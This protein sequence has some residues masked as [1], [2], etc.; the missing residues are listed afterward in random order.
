MAKKNND[1]IDNR[2]DLDPALDF[3]DF[4]FPDPFAKDDRKPAIKIASGMF[5]GAKEGLRDT[6]FLKA[7]LRDTLPQG[8]GQTIDFADKISASARSL[9][10]EGAKEIKP[11]IKDFQRLAAR[12]TPKDS[13]LVPKAIA[14]MIK[15]WEEEHKNEAAGGTLS[16]ERQ[17]EAIVSSQLTEI[18]QAQQTQLTQDRKEDIGRENIKEGIEFTRHRD[19]FSVANTTAVSISRL[20]QYTLNVG[21]K[22]QKKAIELQFRQL[23]A[24]QDTLAFMQKDAAKRDQ[25]LCNISKNTALPEYVKITATESL[26]Q[27]AKN[28][29]LGSVGNGLF[30]ARDNL[31]AKAMG[32]VR[33]KLKGSWADKKFK[34]FDKGHKLA[35]M[36]ENM[37]QKLGD[38][39]RSD[40]WDYDYSLLSQGIRLAQGLLPGAGTD[41]S[42]QNYTSKNMFEAFSFT[43]RS[44]KSLNEVIP[45]LLSRLL[46][47]A[48][49][50]R[51]G[52][53]K[54]ALTEYD[55]DAGRFT[56]AGK[57]E[58]SAMEKVA[59]AKNIQKTQKR[60]DEMVNKIQ[61]EGPALS[62][63]ARA[64]LKERLLKASADGREGVEAN[65]GMHKNY[66][67]VSEGVRDE[68]VPV[69][70]RYLEG[71]SPKER[72]HFSQ[73]YNGLANDVHDSRAAI[74]HQMNMGAAHLLRKEGVINRQ[75]TSI[76][77]KALFERYLRPTR[78]TPG[79]TPGTGAGGSPG[80]PGPEG[81][82]N[83]SPDSGADPNGPSGPNGPNGPGGPSPLPSP[84]VRIERLL[85]VMGDSALST[86]DSAA[87]GAGMGQG[88]QF[89][90]LS[91]D[92]FS[93]D[94]FRTAALRLNRK[95][96][97]LQKKGLKE[98]A[99]NAA[100]AL[101]HGASRLGGSALALLGQGAD[102]L[103]EGGLNLLAQGRGSPH[104][105][106]AQM[107]LL[108][109]RDQA[110]ALGHSTQA[111]ASAAVPQQLKTDLATVGNA[112]RTQAL[113][114]YVLGEVQ[115]R[116][117]AVK[118][119][120]G[121]YR[122][123]VTKKILTHQDQIA[124]EVEDENGNL[125]ISKEELLRLA[126][127][128]AK[129]NTLSVFN[130]TKALGESL[131]QQHAP[132]LANALGTL[133]TNPI[134]AATMTAAL[135]A[136]REATKA[137]VAD[138][139][140][141]GSEMPR[142]LAGK[143][144]AGQYHNA[145]TGEPIFHQ[146]DIASEIKDETGAT[147][148]AADELPKVGTYEPRTRSFLFLRGAARAAWAVTKGLW[149]FQTKIALPM[150]KANLRMLKA[151]ATWG[152]DTGLRAVGLKRDKCKDVY[153]G[154]EREPR[155]YAARMK[156]G[157]YR[158]AKSG[159]VVLHHED[160][161]G[162][163]MD[164]DG[165]IVLSDDDLDN[166]RVY[167][168]VLGLFNPFKLGAK[169]IKAVGRAAWAFQS[170]IA[171]KLSK[172][173][174][175]LMGQGFKAVRAVAR[176]IT[177]PINVYVKGDAKPT[178]LARVMREGG[179][180][181][182]KTKKVIMRASEIDGP[183]EDAHGETLLDEADLE[184]GLTDVSGE[185]I[186]LSLMGKIGQGL[187]KLGKLFSLRRKLAPDRRKTVKDVVQA[188]SENAQQ[189]T[190]ELLEDI[191]AIFADKF[192]KKKA[193]GDSDG[194]GVRDGSYSDQQ[195]KKKK[196]A[197][198]KAAK[199]A[200]N[201][202]APAAKG[203][204][205]LSGVL[206]AADEGSS[207]WSMG[208][209]LLPWLVGGGAAAGTVGAAGAAGT[210][211][212]GTAGAAGAV[213]AAGAAGA[214]VGIGSAA[215]AT[216]GAIGGGL[217]AF[218][219]SPVVLAVGLTALAG[220]GLYKGAQYLTRGD[221]TP[222][223]KLRYVQYGFPLEH[224]EHASEVLG[225]EAY[226]T[227]F[228]KNEGGKLSLNEK[229]CSVKEMV[230]FFG[231][232]HKESKH[233]EI[234]FAWYQNRFKPVFLTH[235]SAIAAIKGKP[236]LS[237]VEGLSPAL[238][239]SYLEAVR[240]SEG[241]YN[242]RCLPLEKPEFKAADGAA[243]QAV[244][245]GL[246][247]DLPA[248]DDKG[249]DAALAKGAPV[250]AV[251]AAALAPSASALSGKSFN[252]GA[253]R[254]SD[255]GETPNLV[256]TVS[257]SVSSANVGPQGR[258][259]ALDAIRMKAYGLTTLEASKVRGLL[260]LE[261]AV[262][263]KMRF[264]S[265]S[266][267]YWQGN[268][269]QLIERLMGSFGISQ[270]YGKETNDWLVWFK[271]RFLP[272]YVAYVSAF[273]VYTGHTSASEGV[274]LL[275]PYQQLELAN[276][277]AGI[278]GVWRENTS[279]WPAYRVG[280][281]T[282]VIRENL[283]ALQA[284][285][286]AA[287]LDEEKKST[288]VASSDSTT[289]QVIKPQVPVMDRATFKSDPPPNPDAENKP[290][291][292][293]GGSDGG[294]GLGTGASSTPAMAGGAMASGTG[295]MAYVNL[296]AGVDLDNLNR[297]LL[298]NFLGMTEEYGQLT[299]KKVTVKDGF[300]TYEA[301]V[302]AKKRNPD[303]AAEPG[304]SMHEFGLAMDVDEKA[305]DAMDKMGLMRKYGLTR[306]VGGEPWHL[307]PAGVQTNYAK[308]KYRTRQ[309]IEMAS[310]A[311]E[312]GVGR[313]GGGLGSIAGSP[314]RTRNPDMARKLLEASSAPTVASAN[315][316]VGLSNGPSGKD[317]PTPAQSLSSAPLPS[318]GQNAKSNP[319]LQ[320]TGFNRGGADAESAPAGGAGNSG[321]NAGSLSGT[322]NDLPADPGV[323][324]PDAKG[325]GAD[326]FRPM[327][328]A[329]AKMVGVDPEIMMNTAA[330]ESSFNPNAK[331]SGENQTASGLF[332]FT[333]KTWNAMLS[334]Y[335]GKYGYVSGVTS[336]FDPKAN[337]IM[338]AH[339]L[340]ETVRTL[341]GKTRRAI[342]S[343]EAYIGHFMGA[344]G[345]SR[346]LNA[347]ESD[348]NA[349]GD[350]VMPAAASNN[351][352]I[353]YDKSGR[354]KTLSEIYAGLD[355]KVR[356]KL[357][358]M[359]GALRSAVAGPVSSMPSS[360]APA[361]LPGLM[362]GVAKPNVI[363]ASYKPK[364]A[365]VTND[366]AGSPLADAYGT[367]PAQQTVLERSS[368]QPSQLSADLFTKTEGLLS[369]SVQV[370][371]KMLEV[372]NKLFGIVSTITPGKST[373]DA[374]A[375]PAPSAP[376]P[377]P[378]T[379]PKVAVPM[380]RVQT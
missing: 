66:H 267:A 329:V 292:G 263:E 352:G 195:T 98:N 39:R 161:R 37:N 308:F 298:K 165:E 291:S 269:L 74:Q 323:K 239:R 230:S 23:F 87:I 304:S 178:L 246:I 182:A 306:P 266:M 280:T 271:N 252:A 231:L 25:W 57:L 350:K 97:E 141:A 278:S 12:I 339:Y 118:L 153:V 206:D 248:K 210:A 219:T 81:G 215:L 187:D 63:E 19:L 190:V 346:F 379:V 64:A 244:Y 312:Q 13:K 4:D 132:T 264:T 196:A 21:L 282:E 46:R 367:K 159:M 90:R 209:K 281:D 208:K 109:Y 33:D 260:L 38:F 135:S 77:M 164:A 113:D 232:D 181:S 96:D 255:E 333:L 16:V 276:L 331:A 202:G 60:L 34:I 105:Q 62:P 72:L 245:E 351:P 326:A 199:A 145:E 103:H 73:Q 358:T 133:R 330:I 158:L 55:F 125:V 279:P 124:G 56:S 224:N 170:K 229:E 22:Y 250:S 296:A 152:L 130:Q 137:A 36:H 83:P 191:K 10:D 235:L 114:L 171:P 275:K 228:L 254:Q 30:T 211:L 237:S 325:T 138:V 180:F 289:A 299:G 140:V 108:G 377:A 222:L 287:V 102:R 242:Y 354:A 203:K 226:M 8:F 11:V 360:G 315:G 107:A 119:L 201:A 104:L 373:S 126:F 274:S 303:N 302:A 285:S 70:R 136:V 337:A 106:T 150:A 365:S 115:P 5:E 207:L 205:M 376:A 17:R 157:G 340:K 305:L 295:A 259:N 84:L 294:R 257:S 241:P 24:T 169:V 193:A 155:L 338:A 162:A 184:T 234:F 369:D 82:G 149:H 142:L 94:K 15:R 89:K 101:G 216:L 75:G 43:R 321:K 223:Q 334:K 364:P 372:L 317:G 328:T 270:E 324:I 139:Y 265:V 221:L 156:A 127:V 301:Q 332:Q 88:F 183:V 1:T 380:R 319:N 99:K 198:A 71:L 362:P 213:G 249:K 262:D 121:A 251:T 147:V 273:K 344:E 41:T 200:Q 378:Y 32:K 357:K 217:L 78:G 20:E 220:Y 26:K 370:Q 58:A 327:I 313:G 316:T 154:K 166:M 52:N 67:G 176:W 35:N 27:V 54:I 177:Q 348:P 322:G 95:R 151:V 59:P 86:L 168:S 345:G 49:I 204:G 129:K 290:S 18:F 9:Y 361:S 189:K 6:A 48:Q 69:M 256:M 368:A 188:R 214:G 42:V 286:K 29:F 318:L 44:D 258:V 277:I 320:L 68:L 47:E 374:A 163:L 185:S 186:R 218:V 31:G 175:G 79:P 93:Y 85:R 336:P 356:G 65:L 283:A 194:D 192:G 347:L 355:A 236:E 225:L 261:Q 238:K 272:V 91:W 3:D 111:K 76:E 128:D 148:L 110:L 53:T 172:I 366:L 297:A 342:G 167:D 300:R 293:G 288:V 134:T 173:T 353:F 359:S 314:L 284:A 116:V 45:G 243:V 50:A 349:R 92:N 144:Q 335:G 253:L 179:Y 123:R 341:A 61:G 112:V 122:D 371:T 131:L 212:A 310:A 268:P 14:E 311:I 7:T 343:T 117:R 160:I 240:F 2:F 174:L 100:N 375:S 307:E 247:K 309:A 146:D 51:T 80:T 120:L 233:L 363:Q 143:L 40:R 197:E 28:R 227:K